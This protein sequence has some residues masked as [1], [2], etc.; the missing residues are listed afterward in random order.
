MRKIL[1]FQAIFH[2]LSHSFLSLSLCESND[3]WPKFS[4]LRAD[5]LIGSVQKN[6]E[7]IDRGN[8]WRHGGQLQGA[9]RV[10]KLEKNAPAEPNIISLSC[11]F[12]IL[13]HL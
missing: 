9:V 1:K 12:F 5:A 7:K 11:R 3:F 10:R 4:I 6:M 13:L 2:I 8:R